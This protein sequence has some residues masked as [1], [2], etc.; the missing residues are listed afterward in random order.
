M[1][2]LDKR[3]LVGDV[4]EKLKEIPNES[5]DCVV[6]SPPYWGLR[7]Y[8]IEGQLGNEKTFQEYLEKMGLVMDE[9]KRVVKTTGSVWINMGDSY[10]QSGAHTKPE[11][12]GWLSTNKSKGKEN[13]YPKEEKRVKGL[14]VKSRIGIP[15]R[16]YINCIDNG[17][18]ARNHIIWQKPNAMPSSV[19]DRLS[20]KY[21]SIFFF[22]KS[23]KYYFDL[24]S[25]RIPMKAV[26][27]Y[28]YSDGVKNKDAD[29]SK[30]LKQDNVKRGDGKIDSTKKGFNKRWTEKYQ[31]YTDDILKN[32]PENFTTGQKG[33]D[34]YHRYEN[35]K[36]KEGSN[37]GD[38]EEKIQKQRD[39]GKHHDIGLGSTD[40]K[41][42]PG[43]VWK[44]RRDMTY[45]TNRPYAVLERKGVVYFRDLPELKD[46]RDY[47]NR[48]RND[49]NI[50]IEQIE[51]HFGNY[52]PHHWFDKEGSYPTREDWLKVKKFLDF[53][54]K[55][56]ENM[57]TE[58]AKPAEKMNHPDGKNPG[59]VW[60]INTKPFPDAHFATFP[61]E[62]PRR[63][64][65]CACPERVCKKCGEPV[66][67]IYKSLG[68]TDYSNTS[69]YKRAIDPKYGQ[70]SISRNSFKK[71]NVEYEFKGYTNCDC[72]EGLEKGIVLD[73]FMGSGT[74]AMVAEELGRGWIGIELNEEYV[75]IIKKRLEN[76]K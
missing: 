16:F 9:L 61:P 41:K 51:D 52:T 31:P 67:K 10:S 39:S 75:D 23:K 56:D 60:E 27:N 47:L 72:N 64:I 57:L 65:K 17:W 32:T 13:Y 68:N 2:S 7:D 59:D 21:E 43:D 35:R 12:L 40:M 70:A 76:K 58:Y 30:F 42:N 26:R 18:T 48:W 73:P 74:T 4:L 71:E 38:A 63:V 46:I 15:E 45:A 5:I 54:D 36:H 34:H 1:E 25:I 37:Y 19:K 66:E 44:E 20:P 62:L 8:G 49:R 53:D 14:A 55:Y 29:L 3:I 11:H 24:E 6:T 50:T 22:V 69:N 28:N 33:L